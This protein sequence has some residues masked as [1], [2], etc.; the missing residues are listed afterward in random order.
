M[1]HYGIGVMLHQ[2]FGSHETPD[3]HYGKKIINAELKDN[4]LI[5]YF[6]ETSGIII[7]DEGQSCCEHRYMTTDDKPSSLIGG[8]LQRIETKD[9]GKADNDY[10]VHEWV[11]LEIATDKSFITIETHNE[12]NGYYGGFALSL[13]SFPGK[14]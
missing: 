11:F 9:S 7:S 14:S 5:L 2:L 10:D 6:T 4:Q 12:H 13:R 8:I 1:T 3:D